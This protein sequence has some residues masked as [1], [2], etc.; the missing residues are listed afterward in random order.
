MFPT[1]RRG[2]LG[3]FFEPDEAMKAARKLRDSE[4]SH[5]DLLTPFPIHGIEEAM[6]QKASWIP[7]VT[8]FLAF[9]GILAAQLMMNYIMVWDWPMNFGGKPFAAWPSFIPVTFELMV[10]FAAIGSAIV[11]ILAGKQDTIPQPPPMEIETGATVDKF[12]IWI[13]ATDPKFAEEPT[14]KFL[15]SLG[16]AGV[17]LVDVEGAKDD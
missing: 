12:V 4:Y 2:A 1:S 10:L 3:H 14:L 15:E 6:G 13:S 7:W 11:A 17:R 8:A 16:A 5:F 9:A